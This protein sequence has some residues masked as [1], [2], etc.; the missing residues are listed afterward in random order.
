MRIAVFGAG[1]IGGYFGAKLAQAGN[2]VVLIAR[3]PHLAAIQ[4]HGLFVESPTGAFHMTPSLATDCP[5]DV[6]DVD[7][8]LLGVKTWDVHAAA[9]AIRP[10]VGATTGVLT[11][12][13]GVEAPAE[14]A[15]VLGADHVIVG[16]AMLRC[17]MAEPGR[18]R[19]VNS[20]DPNLIMG[21]IDN[22]CSERVE[23]LRAALAKVNMTVHVSE[24]IQAQ[25]WGKFVVSA[26]VGG[27]GAVVRVPTGIWRQIPQIRDMVER[28]AQ[29]VVAV[30]LAR[31]VQL[32]E[33][34]LDQV[35]GAI[36]AF[37]PAHMTSMH[38]D[39]VGGRPSELEYWNG[40][41]VRLGREAGV[42]TP[43]NAFIYHSLLPQEMQAR[44]QV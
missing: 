9:A 38:E 29:E 18:L 31:G 5:E 26:A 20:R 11:L 43:L 19:Y 27:V 16:V 28:A 14:V 30:A 42:A 41:V 40:T 33:G 17:L 12:Q 4:A 35:Q 1:G 13:N 8:V 44:G 34:I 21:A 24:N 15:E 2:E 10:M 22:R 36:D 39:I 7:A 23:H 37:A 25:L 6:G 32:P 3:G